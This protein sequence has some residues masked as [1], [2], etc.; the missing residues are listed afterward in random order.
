MKWLST[1]T[2][3]D[4]SV[5][6]RRL[7]NDCNGGGDCDFDDCQSRVSGS[8]RDIDDILGGVSDHRSTP[9]PKSTT[10]DAELASIKDTLARSMPIARGSQ[11]DGDRVRLT[12]PPGNAGQ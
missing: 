12:G 7:P 5:I 10:L 9:A 4:Q 11:F 8:C 3:N 2:T 1:S 6:G